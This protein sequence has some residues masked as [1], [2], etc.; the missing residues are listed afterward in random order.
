ML[1]SSCAWLFSSEILGAFLEDLLGFMI[2]WSWGWVHGGHSFR[3]PPL[4]L[5][6]QP[7]VIL[8]HVT[9]K[10][11]T[12]GVCTLQV[13]P[14]YVYKSCRYHTCLRHTCI[15]LIHCVHILHMCAHILH[16]MY[17]FYMHMSYIYICMSYVDVPV[18]LGQKGFSKTYPLLWLIP[19]H[20][21][22]LLGLHNLQILQRNTLILYKGIGQWWL[23]ECEEPIREIN[24]AWNFQLSRDLH[25]LIVIGSNTQN[26]K[27]V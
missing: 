10:G 23:N 12:E 6:M 16:R 19:T 13:H 26:S 2:S 20:K 21:P 14:L 24:A 17:T 25:I 4:W 3:K 15:H 8:G 9:C 11:A 22:S 27:I 5:P 1:G 18:R 7:G